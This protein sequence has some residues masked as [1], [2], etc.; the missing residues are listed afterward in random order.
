M[1]LKK[2]NGFFWEEKT[3]IERD[4]SRVAEVKVRLKDRRGGSVRESSDRV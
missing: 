4:P 2:P 1:R 3:Q